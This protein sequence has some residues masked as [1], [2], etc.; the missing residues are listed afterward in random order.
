MHIL[1]F[2]YILS[3]VFIGLLGARFNCYYFNTLFCILLQFNQY[4]H[5]CQWEEKR[6]EVEDEI[7]QT[8]FFYL[9][10]ESWKLVFEVAT[11]T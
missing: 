2:S 4:S 11:V 10:R 8:K 7:R 6:K 1:K 3:F 9:K 5:R